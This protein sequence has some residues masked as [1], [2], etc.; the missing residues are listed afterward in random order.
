MFQRIGLGLLVAIAGLGCE[1]GLRQGKSNDISVS[2][3]DLI[4]KRPIQ[5]RDKSDVEV[6][7]IQSAGATALTVDRVYLKGDLEP[8]DLTVLGKTI[9]DD[10]GDLE[11]TCTFLIVERNEVPKSMENGDFM[12]V[13]LV[14]HRNPDLGPL[15]DE[16]PTG[17][18]VI[19]SDATR[20]EDRVKEV[21][22]G[23]EGESPKIQANP[24]VISFPPDSPPGTALEENIIVRN[25]G[26]GTLLVNDIQ[27]RV[28]TPPA[29]DASGSV[30]DEFV[31]L[32]QT[33][34][35]WAVDESTTYT[36]TLQYTPADD[37][38]DSAQIILVSNDAEFPSLVLTAT[39]QPLQGLLLVDPVVANFEL[40]NGE[41]DAAVDFRFQNN[42]LKP[43]EVYDMIIRQ[44][45]MDYRISTAG[46]GN[47]SFQLQAGGVVEGL[48]V[49]Y[50]PADLNAQTDGELFISTNAD[51]AVDKPADLDTIIGDKVIRVPLVH[52][53]STVPGTLALDPLS[54]DL[55]D[56]EAG[57]TGEATLTL[58]NS[59][60]S[61]VQI[62]RIALSTEADAAAG[63]ASDPEFKI[64]SG[65]SAVTL[66]PGDTHEVVVE[67]TR[68]AAD[69]SQHFGAI[70]I[71]SNAEGSP[72]IVTIFAD[73]PPAP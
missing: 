53:I 54:V 9:Y 33:E 70:V 73:A 1:S 10:L 65:G 60:G 27:L 29:K 66:A 52:D 11:E 28:T 12:E 31:L 5:G 43:V 44:P 39:S 42:G 15:T 59:G 34:L 19:E 3:T 36:L 49:L 6:V 35:P 61:P 26:T 41:Y 2:K 64:K 24:P 47:T 17:T 72:H 56:T 18:L 4:F 38:A 23:V 69:L 45:G 21:E 20:V 58:T 62:T 40:A 16:L 67:L 50:H 55:T 30:I 46:G 25:A 37:V 22:L 7:K 63:M 14:F 68:S 8:C 48:A 57:G 13:K 71:E 51:N 32:P